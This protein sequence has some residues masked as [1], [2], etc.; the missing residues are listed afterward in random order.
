[1]KSFIYLFISHS[2]V[3][4]RDRQALIWM[5][6]VPV[7][8]LMLLGAVMQNTGMQINTKMKI[9]VI[10]SCQ[11]RLARA[12]I[13]FLAED[14]AFS[15][16]Q[17]SDSTQLTD[18]LTN[19]VVVL[20]VTNKFRTQS[21]TINVY[22]NETIIPYYEIATMVIEKRLAHFLLTRQYQATIPTIIRKPQAKSQ[23][24]EYVDLLLPGLIGMIILQTGVFMIGV[25]LV[26][27]RERGILRQYGVTP[28][29]KWIFIVAY[30]LPRFILILLQITI[31]TGLAKISFGIDI[32]GNVYLLLFVIFVGIVAFLGIGFLI[33]SLAKT[34]SSASAI[35][36]FVNMVMILLCG[37]FFTNE[38]IPDF[39]KSI[40]NIL[41]LTYL[42]EALRSIIIHGAEIEQIYRHLYI[43]GGFAVVS[44]LISI[45][46]FRWE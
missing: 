30:T 17:L 8:L 37:V 28:L 12:F 42:I 41:P 24:T 43:L 38:M 11:D 35:G 45:K 3:L 29:R 21:R 7:G 14:R 26:N 34:P 46:T 32:S 10:N 40:S 18:A 33:A 23:K 6:M 2:K 16:S 9:A 5:T 15:V 13:D 39:A 20:K 1:M 36:N 31:I 44:I 22:Y 4:L 27:E 25:S 19:N